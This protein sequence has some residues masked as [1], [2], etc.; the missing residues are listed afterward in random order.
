VSLSINL[1]DQAL[2][3]LADALAERVA[4]RLGSGSPWLTAAETAEYLR[5]PVSRVRKLT[6]TAEIPCHRDGRRVLY[7]RE[8]LDQFVRSGGAASP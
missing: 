6:S 7:R 3:A 8:D 4:V 5:C 1:D 2:D